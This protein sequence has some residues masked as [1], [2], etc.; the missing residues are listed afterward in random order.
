LGTEPAARGP[1]ATRS[2]FVE[3]IGSAKLVGGASARGQWA[4]RVDRV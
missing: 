3:D 4:G 1:L 2:A